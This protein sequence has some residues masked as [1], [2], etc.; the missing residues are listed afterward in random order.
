MKVFA[1][2]ID[3]TIITTKPRDKQNQVPIS[4]TPRG[5]SWMRKDN[6]EILLAMKE[7][8]CFVPVTTR[9]IVSYG[10]I[11]FGFVPP[12]A[13]VDN[14]AILLRDGVV[15]EKWQNESLKTV[16]SARKEF[17]EGRQY[18]VDAGL[19]TKTNSIFTIDF[20]DTSQKTEEEMKNIIKT[21][22]HI[23]GSSYDVYSGSSY[24][25]AIHKKMTKLAG[26]QRLIRELNQSLLVTAGDG[27][28]DACMFEISDHSI[29]YE[30]SSASITFK[31]ERN[32]DEFC[33]FVVKTAQHLLC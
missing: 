18:L 20:L 11:D 28:Q 27:G 14:G 23:V 24:V 32:D 31:G 5:T 1:T 29:G 25:Y 4:T 15:D 10:T 13:L 33:S 6:H 30:G 9:G 21:F 26:L 3:G 17:E 22:S 16:E 7:Q 12:Y 8:I 2:D 19:Q